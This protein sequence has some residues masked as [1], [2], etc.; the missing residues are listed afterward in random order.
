[1]MSMYLPG[2]FAETSPEKLFA[3]IAEHPLGTLYDGAS[4]EIAHLPFLAE[5]G[6]GVLRGHVARRNPIAARLDGATPMTAV[7]LGPDGYIS[8]RWYADRAEVPTWNYAAVHAR[9]RP[10]ALEDPLPLLREMTERFEE[11]GEDRWRMEEVPGPL[12]R[13]LAGEIVAFEMAVESI[14]GKFKL[15]QNR[16]PADRDGAIRGLTLRRHAKDADLARFMAAP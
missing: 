2:P 8:P 1:M 12:L 7:F 10:R 13:E 3:L 5:P 4:G 14:A 15:S 6:R 16:S 11:F 9:G